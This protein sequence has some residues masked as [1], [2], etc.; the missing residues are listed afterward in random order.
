MVIY[1]YIVTVLLIQYNITVSQLKNLEVNGLFAAVMS[2]TKVQIPVCNKPWQGKQNNIVVTSNFYKIL[3]KYFVV[4]RSYKYISPSSLLM[5]NSKGFKINSPHRV[6]AQ[7]LRKLGYQGKSGMKNIC[8]NTSHSRKKKDFLINSAETDGSR[9]LKTVQHTPIPLMAHVVEK[10]NHEELFFTTF[11]IHINKRAPRT[12]DVR[13]YVEKCPSLWIAK[14]RYRQAVARVNFILETTCKYKKN[15]DKSDIFKES[16]KQNWHLLSHIVEKI[17]KQRK[18]QLYHRQSKSITDDEIVMKCDSQKWTGLIVVDNLPSRGKGIKT[19]RTFEKGELICDYHGL[20]L[21][22]KEGS[23]LYS[24]MKPGDMGYMFSFKI[25]GKTFWIDATSNDCS[26]GRLIN[27]SKKHPNVITKLKLINGKPIL[28]MYANR[29]IQPMEKLLHN[30]NC[31]NHHESSD[32]TWL[33]QCIC[34]ECSPQLQNPIASCIDD[35]S[36]DLC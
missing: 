8:Q 26:Y 35:D 2:D 23:K 20:L 22:G 28:L 32:L 14:W 9:D 3:R 34:Q 24:D 13:K 1:G 11:P 16:R 33:N 36:D 18:P 30:Y 21:P 10:F 31:Q 4:Y 25:D 15:I 19:L 7:F 29:H 12:K 5:V 6:A 27:H 17:L